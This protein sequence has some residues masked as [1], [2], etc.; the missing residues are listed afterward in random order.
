MNR[1]KCLTNTYHHE[2]LSVDNMHYFNY[3]LYYKFSEISCLNME[4]RDI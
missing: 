1:V 4:M 3:F 2:T